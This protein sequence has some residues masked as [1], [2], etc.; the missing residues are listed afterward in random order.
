[1]TKIVVLFI[2]LV[3]LVSCKGGQDQAI[4]EDTSSFE[5]Q[6]E[7]WSKK[8]TLN[9]KAA[10][11][12]KNWEAFNALQASFDAV[13]KVGNTEDLSL[14]LEDLIEKQKVLET[15][16][17]PEKLNK[18]QIKSRQKVFHTYILKTKG[19]LV[20]RIDAQ[21]SVLQM[22]DAHNSML[23]QINVITNNTLDL[24]SLLDPEEK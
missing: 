1:M 15:S 10:E 21:K 14:V 17:Y 23:N 8:T 18:A 19:D 16:K 24:K 7:K 20:Y 4:T 3:L 6:T 22:I 5:L 12:T 11:I 2:F 13:Y 9:S